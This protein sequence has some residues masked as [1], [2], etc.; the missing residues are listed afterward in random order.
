[1][2]IPE[3]P[4]DWQTLAS[5]KRAALTALIPPSWTL[6]PTLLDS[7]NPKG[8][9]LSIPA[10][11]GIFTARELL[12]TTS[13]DA[14]ALLTGLQSRYL[15]AE[16]VVT[17]FCKRAAVAHQ[18]VNCL[19]EIMFEEAI[20]RAREVDKKREAGEEVGRLAGLP[21]SL[22][23]S[24]NITG[25]KTTIGYVSYASNP[26]A[27]ADSALITLLRREGAIFYC[28]TNLPQTMMTADSHNNL[29]GRTLNPNNLS[30]TAGGSTGGEGALLRMCGSVLGIAT[31]IAGSIRIPALCNGV[32]GFKPTAGRIPFA[33]KVPPARLGSPSPIAPVIGPL[34]RSIRDFELFM[35]TVIDAEP[36]DV[37][38]N[39]LAVPWRKVEPVTRPLRFGLIR[40]HPKRP[41]HPP[42][43]R[44]LHTAAMSLKKAGHEMVLLDDRIP[45]LWECAVLAWKFFLLDP[46]KTPAKFVQASGEPWVPSITTA[47]FPE[48]KGWEASLDELFDMNVERAKIV[49]RYHDIVIE[50]RLD[51]IIMPGNQ[52]TAPP[53]DTYGVAPYT[54]LANLLNYPAG[55]LPFL[56]AN[57]RLDQP[58][59]NQVVE[60]VPPYNP[61]LFEGMP[62]AVQILGK[63]MKDEETIEILKV[64]ESVL[65][66]AT[67]EPVKD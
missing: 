58:F 19:T 12:I 5:Q 54:V 4:Q 37:D 44:T 53:H 17:A 55:I 50:N 7:L 21:V 46:Q 14:T 9:A 8:S 25:T 30:L 48:L 63:P 57:R 41:L 38:P 39:V 6:S 3:S 23:D 65:K 32:A 31:D 10:S 22:K 13:Y 47:K 45:D 40:G 15:S 28:K 29:F 2:T 27:S 33:G 56:T 11:S 67:E 18:C 34:G 60:Y 42:V 51:A 49:A 35:K 64:V 1:M 20:A 61:E 62:G 52:S 26:P 59:M 24:F 66:K 43:A 16:E 36:W